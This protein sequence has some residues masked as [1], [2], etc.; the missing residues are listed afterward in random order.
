MKYLFSLFLL[1]NMVS[2]L[3]QTTGTVQ[4]VVLAGAQPVPF[5]SVGVAGTA[6]GTTADEA[7]RFI[8]SLRAALDDAS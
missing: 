1:L 2:G 8:G 6:L 7:G 4:G 5:A 3:A